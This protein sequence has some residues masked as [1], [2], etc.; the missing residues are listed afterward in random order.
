MT[1]QKKNNQ[2]AQKNIK[3]DHRQEFAEITVQLKTI[4]QQNKE[5]LRHSRHIQR[6]LLY[7]RIAGL[8]KIFI[9]IIPIVLGIIYLPPLITKF[10]SQ[11]Q[12]IISPISPILEL[13]ELDVG[14]IPITN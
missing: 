3:D 7:L 10:Y 6:S 12:Q 9:I 2:S 14:G 1:E 4:I 11:F 13:S 8:V 5:I